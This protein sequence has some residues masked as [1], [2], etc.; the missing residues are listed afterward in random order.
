MSPTKKEIVVNTLKNGMFTEEEVCDKAGITRKEFHIIK[1][2]LKDDGTD[3]GFSTEKQL[4]FLNTNSKSNKG[5]FH[6]QNTSDIVRFG[7]IADTH[8]CSNEESL[9]CLHSFYQ[10][11][12]GE[13]ISVVYHAGDMTDGMDVY[14]GHRNNLKVW[15]VNQQID[16]LV[17]NYPNIDG[18]VTK[19]ISGNHDLKVHSKDGTDIGTIIESKRQDLVYLGQTSADID[20]KDGCIMRIVHP[21][22]SPAYAKSYRL[23]K[24]VDGIRGGKKT[25][26]LAFGHFHGSLYM[27]YSNVHCFL[28][29]AFQDENEFTRSRGMNVSV[30]GWILEMKIDK[31]GSLDS[32]KSNWIHYY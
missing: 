23:Q 11:C 13:G 5:I 26:I 20:L 2:K 10:L 15:G 9:D 31:E 24:Y 30:G 18:L 7:L 32:L 22:G 12:A 8:L 16:Y 14:P 28:A 17:E 19:W 1:K 21:F 4:Y 6:E 27:P 29:G 25:N 3:I